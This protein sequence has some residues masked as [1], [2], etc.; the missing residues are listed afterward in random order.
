MVQVGA[1]WA[2]AQVDVYEEHVVTLRAWSILVELRGL[3]PAPPGGAWSRSAAL[4]R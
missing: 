3:L 1:Q 2:P 4:P